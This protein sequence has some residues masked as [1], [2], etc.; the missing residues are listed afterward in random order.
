MFAREVWPWALLGVASGLVEGATVAVLIKKGFAGLVAAHW[1]DFAVA[2]VSG[3]PALANISSFAWA[4]LAHGRARIRVLTSLQAAFA[5][6]VG[7]VALAPTAASGLVVTILSVLVAR[8]LWAGYD[9]ELSSRIA[10]LNNVSAGSFAGAIIAALFLKRF[11]TA[12]PQWLHLDLYAW[13][14]KDRPGRPQ[15]AEAQGL[16]ALYA[17]IRGRFG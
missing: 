5:I 17:L 7:L 9:E 16:R 8:A 14:P 6:S 1:V 15:G 12:T 13:N 2:L 11:V 3:A 10:D 4:N